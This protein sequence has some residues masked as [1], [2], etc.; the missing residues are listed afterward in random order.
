MVGLE[1][2]E[3]AFWGVGEANGL[4]GVV[5][6]SL[7]T[8]MLIPPRTSSKRRICPKHPAHPEFSSVGRGERP[9]VSV[10]DNPVPGIPTVVRV[11]EV[12]TV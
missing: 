12:P 3:L 6:L 2:W 7:R 11:P 9:D 1:V 10:Y 5:S 4:A 8:H